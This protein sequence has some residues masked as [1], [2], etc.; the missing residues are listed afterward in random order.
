MHRNPLRIGTSPRA[1]FDL[2]QGM[3]TDPVT[4]LLSEI[5]GGRRDHMYRDRRLS[6][7]S[8]H[9]A[10][11]PIATSLATVAGQDYSDI[12]PVVTVVPGDEVRPGGEL[13]YDRTWPEIRVVSPVAG[14]ISA[15]EL[16]HGRRIKRIMIE[17]ALGAPIARKVE[18]GASLKETLLD[19]GLWPEFRTRPFGHIPDPSTLPDAIFIDALGG[20]DGPNAVA[21]RSRPV[22][23]MRGLDALVEF[24]PGRVFFCQQSGD[25]LAEG[26]GRIHLDREAGDLATLGHRINR[27]CSVASG[28]TV[29]TIGCQAVIAIGQLRD[30][31][32]LDPT[33]L[34]ALADRHG[35]MARIV[36]TF[37]GADLRE[38]LQT[39]V[40]GSDL[41][42]V[43]EASR[44]L[45]ARQTQAALSIFGREKD[46]RGVSAGARPRRPRPIVPLP[47]LEA[48][49]PAG[50][51]AIP[52]LRALS[53]GDAQSAMRLG[54]LDLLEEDMGPASAICASRAEYGQLLRQVLSELEREA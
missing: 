12:R 11:D 26:G 13:F 16:G 54:C 5:P 19:C 42:T 17:V 32:V 43:P 9:R 53:I 6:E 52:L 15:V 31:G 3:A 29:W 22:A 20:R 50:I 46:A 24:T 27:L 33:R 48:T 36:R 39:T 49:L 34:V 4:K 1:A 47:A 35:G 37:P 23:L 8:S 40:D 18:R 44:W 51:R 30:T 41:Y 10:V 38:I 14:R 25:A 21:A 2:N 28:G 45:G 7:I